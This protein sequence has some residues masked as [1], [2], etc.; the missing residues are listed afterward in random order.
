MSPPCPRHPARP[1]ADTNPRNRRAR[2][3]RGAL[4]AERDQKDGEA[5]EVGGRRAGGEQM[6][7]IGCALEAKG[8]SDVALRDREVE[9]KTHPQSAGESPGPA[10]PGRSS[11]QHR[12]Q[13]P[14]VAVQGPCLPQPLGDMGSA[15]WSIL[16]KYICSSVKDTQGGSG[17]HGRLAVLERPLPEHLPTGPQPPA[18]AERV[19]S[20][21][22]GKR[23]TWV[24]LSRQD[25]H[26]LTSHL[27]AAA[28]NMG[29]A[30]IRTAEEGRDTDTGP[31]GGDPEVG[32]GGEDTEMSSGEGDPE[33]G[34][35]ERTQK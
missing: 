27:K 26:C 16:S 5:Q 19:H 18:L 4:S 9:R 10:S 2:Q 35:R 8:Q 25:S 6:T 32:P 14:G 34:L 30:Q 3:G 17:G 23:G 29:Q 1:A 33:V 7:E 13:V 12:R 20:G 11:K 21:P 31:E 24:G 28:L 15:H 22:Q